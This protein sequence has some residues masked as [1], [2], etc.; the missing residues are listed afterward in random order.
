MR[1]FSLLTPALLALATSNCAEAARNPKDS[2]LLSRIKT[3]TFRKDQMT[4]ARR[5]SP[6]PQLE[7][8]GGDA[9][10]LYEVDIMRCKNAGSDYDDENVQWTCQAS[11][12]EEF[13][14][15]STD[16]ICEGYDS[17]EDPF[18][19]K[20]SC[21]VEYRLMLTPKG[22]EKYGDR[23]SS[24]NNNYGLGED[25][26]LSKGISILFWMLFIAVALWMFFAACIVGGVC[27]AI[28]EQDRRDRTE[29][30]HHPGRALPD[31]RVPALERR[32]GDE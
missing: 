27:G 17:P 3:L 5:V 4:T 25:E 2:V 20:G 10:G 31:T 30:L 11:L 28:P 19:L 29:A 6:I 13:K 24:W 22:V 23:K 12:P 18:V 21:G 1:A 26:K 16:V 32:D 15:G 7:C 8:I 14:L 9:K